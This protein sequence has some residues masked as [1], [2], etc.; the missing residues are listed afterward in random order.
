MSGLRIFIWAATLTFCSCGDEPP[1]VE[2]VY[3]PVTY[4][5]LSTDYMTRSESIGGVSF[6]IYFPRNI[7]SDLP[8]LYFND[9][10]GFERLFIAL[11][12]ES[13][14]QVILVGL[15]A[16]AN[17]NDKYIPYDDPWVQANWGNY[18]P[19]AKEY[20]DIIVNEIIPY[21]DSEFPTDESR[22]AIFGIS[23]GGL[24]ATYA[25]FEYPEVFSFSAG[26]SP[27]YWVADYKI[28]EEVPSD[29][30]EN[31]RVYF[32]I[33]TAEWNYYL[34]LIPELKLKGLKYGE[35]IFYY[36]VEG[37]AHTPTHWQKRMHIPYKIFIEDLQGLTPSDV[38][39]LIECI[40]S[41]SNPGRTF[42]RINPVASFDEGIQYSL[43]TECNYE[44][45]QGEGVVQKDGQFAVDGSNLTV[46][47]SYKAW[48][49][50]LTL[51]NC[52]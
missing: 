13:D 37:A 34:P 20:T 32:D 43:T 2:P 41:Q 36:E 35:Q 7:T 40:P 44:I 4:E 3:N 28:L 24:H 42:Q 21:I 12:E 48:S 23:L 39:V 33:G 26:I 46:D 31:N 50:Q 49:D 29:F 15:E 8:V 10:D 38:N 22:R 45:I 52:R 11:V 1:S 6:N 51:S 30:S 25:H 18:E 19:Q 17:R 47:I 27:S 16:G 14:R 9:G 5:P